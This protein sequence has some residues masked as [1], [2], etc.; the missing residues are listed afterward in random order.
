[1]KNQ[2]IYPICFF[3]SGAAGLIYQI[4]W[5][6]ILSLVF[7]NTTYAV[8]MVVAGF[9]SG[10]ALGSYFFGKKVD[11]VTSPVRMYIRLEIG[12]A[13]SALAVTALIYALDDAIVRVMTVESIESGVWQLIRFGAVFLILLI[14]TSLIGGTSPVMGKFYVNNFEKVGLGIGSL[15]AA[16]TY[17]AMSGAF[18]SGFLLVPVLGVM[19]TLEIALAL[20]LIVAGAIWLLSRKVLTSTEAQ[21][22]KKSIPRSKRKKDK[23]KFRSRET[24]S[25]ARHLISAGLALTLMTLAGFCA[26][27]FEILWTRAFVVSFKST[28]YLFSILLTVF[29]FGMA[30]GSH[31]FSRLLDKNEDPLRL[32]AIAQI[33]IGLSGIMSIVFFTFSGDLALMLGRIIGKMNWTTDMLV[34]LLLMVIVFLFP[35]FCM[36]LAY[37]L[38]CRV[39]T[40]SLKTLGLNIGMVFTTG[41]IGGVVGTLLS[42]FFFLPLF[43]LQYSIF[44]VS[45]IALVTGYIGLFNAASRKGLGWLFPASAI[46]ALV[47][48]VTLEIIGVNIGL[49][50]ETGEKIIY[51]KEGVMGTVRVTQKKEKG[52]LTLL[53]NAYQLATSGDV[54]VRFGHLPLLLKPEAKDVLLISLG[55]GITAGSVGGHPVERI[56]CVEILPTLLNI[57]RFFKEHNHKI[58]NDNR[59]N[60]TFWDGRN[61]V[62]VTKRKY[63][64]VISDLFQPDS[65]GVGNLYTLEHFLNVKYKLKKEGA[66]A[67]W[68]PLYQLSPENLK[69]IIRTFATAFEYVTVWGGDINSELPTLML[70]GSAQPLR[71]NPDKFAKALERESVKRDMIEYEDPMSLLSFFIMDRDGAMDF[72]EGYSINTDD[73][74]VIEYTAPQN[75]W[76]RKQNTLINFSSLIERRQKVTAHIM[77]AELDSEFSNVIGS[78]YDGRTKILQGKVE[79]ANH[80]YPA[81]IKNYKEAA[82]LVPR[83]PNLAFAIFDLGYL[84]YLRRDYKT[85]SKLFDWTRQVYPNLLEAHFYLAKSYENLGMKKAATTAFEELAKLR[86]DIA[87]ML[88]I[89]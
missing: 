65:A 44:I 88:K 79:H 75:I 74:P 78:Y 50:V 39:T 43:G 56:D 6:R 31:V 87:E 8:A 33:I 80:N 17:G 76:N 35:T 47:I 18:F 23:K 58:I 15:Y 10:L 37:P 11:R 53:V 73:K 48:F 29:L 38:I 9:L 5:I 64:L 57:Q 1:M 22:K 70:F 54:A 67:Q 3:F 16:N 66:M 86:P 83:D 68:L 19:G 59:F 77:G 28:I 40:R 36:G 13:V 81:Q 85:S 89:K 20:N 62:R 34:M 2:Y 72:T 32:F 82:K 69:V 45:I 25:G 46:S 49:G 60:L 4:A 24:D 84:Y 12:I 71:I 30:L 52:P 14:P 7:G 63:D 41:T 51:A 42:G 27:S 55:S 26:L 61:Y 21:T